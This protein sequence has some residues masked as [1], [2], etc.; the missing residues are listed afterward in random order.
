[1]G[2]HFQL[3]KSSRK[4]LNENIV[5]AYP[6]TMYIVLLNNNG[7]L[8]LISKKWTIILIVI[9][10]VSII[11][12]VL[13]YII[14]INQPLAI[15]APILA[16]AASSLTLIKSLIP[17]WL[18]YR[19]KPQLEYGDL[20]NSSLFKHAKLYNFSYYIRIKK[21]KGENAKSVQGFI[22]IEGTEIQNI[23]LKWYMNNSALIDIQDYEDLWLF[24][25][26][27]NSRADIPSDISN[28]IIEHSSE[29][30]KENFFQW[31]K[32]VKDKKVTVRI[33]SENAKD[34]P[35]FSEMLLDIMSKAKA[36]NIA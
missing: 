26:S 12:L 35:K 20:I 4:Q 8:V 21:I 29:Q 22:T 36:S 3:G 34:M 19:K 18:E 14:P 15:I 16:I 9:T 31:Y 24:S 27:T 2:L 28:I 32:D 30:I 11:F 10:L 6:L 13:L 1:M 7:K 25:L 5:F 33:K 17:Q 23:P